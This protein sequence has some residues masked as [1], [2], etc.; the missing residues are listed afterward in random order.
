MNTRHWYNFP[1][2][3]GV[4][5]DN[6]SVDNGIILMKPLSPSS[7]GV[8]SLREVGRTWTV[9]G[10]SSGVVPF[11]VRRYIRMVKLLWPDKVGHN[12]SATKASFCTD[13]NN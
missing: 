8:A 5:V 7:L 4:S 3:H 9:F 10:G 13:R 12:V 1:N 11:E 2:V 6:E